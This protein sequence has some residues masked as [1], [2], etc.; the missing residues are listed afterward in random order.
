[1]TRVPDPAAGCA[2]AALIVALP[3][4][5]GGCQ[6]GMPAPST[7]PFE[8]FVVD[9]RGPGDPW[10]KSVGDI[11]GDGRPDLV[12]GGHYGGGLV[13]YENP[14]W[15]KHVIASA[16]AFS[17]DHEVADVDGDGRNDVVSLMEDRLVWFR[18]AAGRWIA[19]D[20]DRERLHDVEIADLDGDG[21]LDIVARGQLAFEGSGHRVHLYYQRVG[22]GWDRLIIAVPPGEG[23]AVRDIDGDGRA[24]IVINGVWLKN[25]VHR[26]AE[27][28]RHVYTRSW[29]WSHTH[30]AIGD[31][32]GDGRPDIVL[33]PAETA[34][35]R[36]RISWFEAPRDPTLEWAERVIDAD[37]E[38]VHHFVGVADLDM[39]GRADVVSAMM[40]SGKPPTEIKIYVNQ[41]F[42]SSWHKQV[43]STTGSHSMRI[44]DIDGD[45]D[46]DL[47][48]ANFGGENQNPE[49]WINSTCKRELGCP[50]WRRHEV[51]AARPGKAVFI[52]AAD[53][54]GD[55]RVDIA[56][57]SW[58]YRNP[59]KPGGSW[60][61]SAFGDPAY[62]VVLMADFD[63]DGD[64][65]ALAT[66]WRQEKDDA[67]FVYAE[68][69]GRGHFTLR[70]DMPVGAGDFL[71]GVAL[72]R[73]TAGDRWQVAL[74]WHL[75]EKGVWLLTVPSQPA[76][77]PWPLEQISPVSQDEALSVGDI[78][79]DG[80][81]DLLLG[82][83]W[84]RNESGGW[85]PFAI[86]P[87]RT[88][89]DRNRLAD[90]NGDGRLDA[91]V[92][93]EAISRVG[94]VVWYEQGGDAAKP[95]MRHHVG[96]ATGPMSLDVAD[97]DNDGDLDIVVG[98]HDLE[99][100]ARARLVLFENQ[101]GKGT[102]WREHVIFTGDEHHDGA[103]AVD[104]DGDG[105]FDVL[106][107]GWGHGK[108]LLYERLTPG[109]R[110]N[111]LIGR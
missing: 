58:W 86:D 32:N 89:P 51:D 28:Q 92:G 105:D 49:L 14:H 17:T 96:T 24:D 75:P 9:R 50:C 81:P 31:V 30:V 1:M 15:Q 13:W 78:D 109:C 57:G 108:V 45:G 79:R 56:A 2:A 88:N 85:R 90:M 80:R 64:T 84:L 26:D 107:I 77:E 59:G 61:R 19:Q 94:D 6:D 101:D 48:G 54:D 3:L 25:P 72:G 11:N 100:P 36:Y 20:I 53:L 65:D 18:N 66:R 111:A 63:G 99:N 47:F 12:V 39:D 46:P 97:V 22:G 40:H 35:R 33:S 4:C 73:F 76:R 62:D 37:V 10:G 16:G 29:S 5:V 44:V 104:M 41:D 43:L 52:S 42:G 23:L 82:T 38:A 91:I 102:R 87:A 83:A 71:Q 27:W 74:S 21:R 103:V 70:T 55:G 98:E 93:F 8:R 60:E 7:V 110:V 106:S 68:N 67:R 69:D 95:W 34:G